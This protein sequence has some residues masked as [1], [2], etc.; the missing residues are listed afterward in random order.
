MQVPVEVEV[1]VNSFMPIVEV[2]AEC[3]VAI[4]FWISHALDFIDEGIIQ[5]GRL[6]PK[7]P[8]ENMK[9]NTLYFSMIFKSDQEAMRYAK[10]LHP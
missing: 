8:K 3:K 2:K 9:E 7:E 10:S 1:R 6:L 4:P 5:G